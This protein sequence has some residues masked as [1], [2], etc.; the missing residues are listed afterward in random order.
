MKHDFSIWTDGSVHP[1]AL[2][3]G[4][5]AGGCHYV[6]L[7]GD[8]IFSEGSGQDDVT[9][10]NVI[11]LRAVRLALET[12]PE[13]ASASVFTDSRNVIGWMTGTMKAQAPSIAAEVSAL[14][15][16]AKKRGLTVTFEKVPAH[17][18]VIYN[19]QCDAGAKKAMNAQLAQHDRSQAASAAEPTVPNID[20]LP[21][22]T[23]ENLKV[24]T[25]RLHVTSR[26][27]EYV[28]DLG[29]V[30]ITS[31]VFVDNLDAVFAGLLAGVNRAPENTPLVVTCSSANHAHWLRGTF[32]AKV[33]RVVDWV[34]RIRAAAEERGITLIVNI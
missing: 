22:H 18:G 19:E 9:G 12:L 25:A 34:S 8:T 26:G 6:V 7:K 24:G 27:R 23:T 15:T 30:K 11:E 20:A 3:N 32:K 33:P 31:T 14:H 13:K 5:K 29:H 1:T 28:A 2:A 10:I 21:G 4:L 17:R 16:L